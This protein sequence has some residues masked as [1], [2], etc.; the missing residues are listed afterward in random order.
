[1]DLLFIV[2][3]GFV[4][5]RFTLTLALLSLSLYSAFGFAASFAGGF[6][7]AFASFSADFASG[8]EISTN[9]AHTF[10]NQTHE[11]QMPNKRMKPHAM[12]NDAQHVS[13]DTKKQNC[14]E[15]SGSAQM[16]VNQM[17]KTGMSCCEKECKSC[18]SHHSPVNNSAI[19]I[20]LSVIKPNI[21]FP[22]YSDAFVAVYLNTPSKPPLFS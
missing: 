12:P 13:A 3:W 11:N 14:H 15:M 7:G 22:S 18:F 9:S 16:A 2:V 8:V 10:E 6:S 5:K 1:M 4:K 19:N 17:F 20:Q 21:S